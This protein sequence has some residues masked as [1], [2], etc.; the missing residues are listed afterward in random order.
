MV[1]HCKYPKDVEYIAL[2]DCKKDV[3]S[4]LRFCNTFDAAINSEQKLLLCRAGKCQHIFQALQSVHVY[5]KLKLN[6]NFKKIELNLNLGNIKVLFLLCRNFQKG[7]ARM[8]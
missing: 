5:F 1:T 4:H 2:K 6:G 8:P 3:T 7:R